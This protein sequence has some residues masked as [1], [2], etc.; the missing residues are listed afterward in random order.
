MQLSHRL[1]VC[2]QCSLACSPVVSL[3]TSCAW[4]RLFCFVVWMFLIC[5]PRQPAPAHPRNSLLAILP[6]GLSMPS[7]TMEIHVRGHNRPPPP[8]RSGARPIPSPLELHCHPSRNHH[9][10]TTRL[11]S[12]PGSAPP[13]LL[14]QTYSPSQ[15]APLTSYGA[16]SCGFICRSRS[17]PQGPSEQR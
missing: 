11:P 3:A 15:G 1:P 5:C 2:S 8:D 14:R 12:V 17:L 10:Q 6:V 4:S 7:F 13:L 9:H 16:N